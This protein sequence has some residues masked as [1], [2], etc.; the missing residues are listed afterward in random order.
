MKKT[1]A[2]PTVVMTGGLVRETMSASSGD[3]EPSGFRSV[4]GSVGFNL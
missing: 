2:A 1:Y 4:A 3:T